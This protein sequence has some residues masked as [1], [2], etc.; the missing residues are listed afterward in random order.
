MT[1]IVGR[2]SMI[3]S[4]PRPSRSHWPGP[5]VRDPARNGPRQWWRTALH[6]TPA[7]GRLLNPPTTSGRLEHAPPEEIEAHAAVHLPL[8]QRQ[9][10][11]LTFGL[12]MEPEKGELSRPRLFHVSPTTRR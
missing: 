12:T 1:Y 3:P 11:D 2:V 9:L 8:E 10:I 7:L 5:T 6:L 4:L